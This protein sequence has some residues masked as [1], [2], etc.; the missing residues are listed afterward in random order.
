MSGS[1]WMNIMVRRGCSVGRHTQPSGAASGGCAPLP[2]LLC[3]PAD[4]NRAPHSRRLPAAAL[5]Q[6]TYFDNTTACTASVY[7][8]TPVLDTSQSQGATLTN[9]GVQYVVSNAIGTLGLPLD[10][11]S[12]YLVLGDATTTNS[13]LCT[14]FCGW[15]TY[16]SIAG[17]YVKFA[18]IGNAA[19]CA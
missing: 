15:H 5:V 17:V 13:G 12:I 7:L 11:N 8:G 18:F 4:R 2:S 14:S 1:P 3:A 10:G 16:G 19:R 6:T 9:A